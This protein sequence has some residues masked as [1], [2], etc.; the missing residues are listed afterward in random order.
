MKPSKA[1][2]M[3]LP[4]EFKDANDMLKE[5]LH[6][7]YVE[8]WWAAKT[9]TPSGVLVFRKTGTSIRIERRKNLFLILG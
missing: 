2:L 7:K 3:S 5:R 8:A 4:E 1:K 6:K 9:Y